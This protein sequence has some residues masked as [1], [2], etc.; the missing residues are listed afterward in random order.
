MAKHARHCPYNVKNTSLGNKGIQI[1]RCFQGE[2][3][4]R[5]PGDDLFSAQ[6]NSGSVKLDRWLNLVVSFRLPTIKISLRG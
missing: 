5:E 4:V 3:R 6:A 1:F 2:S